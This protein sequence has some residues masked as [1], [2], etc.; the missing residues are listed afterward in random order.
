[1]LDDTEAY[2]KDRDKR[3]EEMWKEILELD[4]IWYG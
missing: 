4:E 2:I 3:R 1:M